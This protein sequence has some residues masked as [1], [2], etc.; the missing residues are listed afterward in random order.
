MAKIQINI[1]FSNLYK[2]VKVEILLNLF[3]NQQREFP[4]IFYAD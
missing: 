1:S 3:T 4:I 2:Q